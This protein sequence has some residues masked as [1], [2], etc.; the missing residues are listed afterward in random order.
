VIIKAGDVHD[1]CGHPE[2][3]VE[4][5]EQALEKAE[6]PYDKEGVYERLIPLYEKLGKDEEAERIRRME[7]QDRETALPWPSSVGPL[8]K[9]KIGRND[10]CPCG[11]GR[12]YK[13]CCLNKADVHGGNWATLGSRGGEVSRVRSLLARQACQRLWPISGKDGSEIGC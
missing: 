3:A 6:D 9:E 7:E 1:Q 2:K 13:K 5:Y 8:R 4:L 11:S 10:P 12:K